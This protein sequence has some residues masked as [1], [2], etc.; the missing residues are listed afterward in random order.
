[1]AVLREASPIWRGVEEERPGAFRVRSDESSCR[2]YVQRRL[3]P[4]PRIQG[5]DGAAKKISVAL[6]AF[7]S[8]DCSPLQR[9]LRRRA[10]AACCRNGRCSSGGPTVAGTP[11]RGRT[12]GERCH[13]GAGRVRGSGASHL[14]GVL[15]L[16]FPG[17]GL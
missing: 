6:V 12:R 9:A 16:S 14:S 2:G 10:A 17:V 15:L 4:E 7:S 5:G 13:R 11:S 8:K 1:M 3:S